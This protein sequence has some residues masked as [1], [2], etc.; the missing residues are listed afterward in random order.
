MSKST[1]TPKRR[2]KYC[3][4]CKEEVSMSVIREAEDEDDLWWLLC[5]TCNSKFALTNTEYR[6]EKRPDISVIKQSNARE[7]HTD[8]TYT[9]GELIYHPKLDDMGMVVGKASPPIDSC[10]GAIIV[11]FVEAGQKTLIEGYAA[12]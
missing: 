8:Q 11:S 10:S 5:P 3:T 9:V 12:A 4:V 1:R 2:R 7:Y 6:K